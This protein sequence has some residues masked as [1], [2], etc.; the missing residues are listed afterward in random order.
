MDE[1]LKVLQDGVANLKG[2]CG[3]L[4]SAITYANNITRDAEEKLKMAADKEAKLEAEKVAVDLRAGNIAK[5]ENIVA[6]EENGKALLKEARELTIALE[7]EKMALRKEATEKMRE[8]S[9]QANKNTNDRESLDKEYAELRKEQAQFKVDKANMRED[10][11]K[12][13]KAIK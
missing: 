10:I 7:N 3:N 1:I 12:N 9:S 13:L 11:L 6:M 8:V 4:A 2:L 5:V